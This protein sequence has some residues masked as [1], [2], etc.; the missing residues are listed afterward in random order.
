[1]TNLGTIYRS[2]DSASSWHPVRGLTGVTI[3]A[4]DPQNPGI[5]DVAAGPAQIGSCPAN[6]SSGLW[7]IFR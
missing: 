1:V 7:E 2:T 4:A 3:F 5:E 6:R